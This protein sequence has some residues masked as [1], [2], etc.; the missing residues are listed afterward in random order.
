MN[1]LKVADKGGYGAAA[2]EMECS[3]LD[4]WEGWS[5][6]TA[7]DCYAQTL[8]GMPARSTRR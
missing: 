3:F 4:L 6:K 1:S 8:L 2:G 5:H 7:K